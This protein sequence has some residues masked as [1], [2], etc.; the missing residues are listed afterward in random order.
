MQFRTYRVS[1]RARLRVIFHR[2]RVA[3]AS[4]PAQLEA[5]AGQR[6]AD[7]PCEMRPPLAPIQAR[8]AEHPLARVP[9]RRR[10]REEPLP[11]LGHLAAIGAQRD[12]PAVAQR[13]GQR[14][15]EPPGQV[16]VAGARGA[17][18]LAAAPGGRRA[19]ARVRPPPSRPPACARPAARPAGIA[20]A[21]LLLPVSSP[22][23]VSFARWPLVVCGD[24]WAA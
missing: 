21:A 15:A 4:D 20:V 9:A 24:T 13:I 7:A 18:R 3:L 19:P 14:D 1:R 8:P 2:A 12:V 5:P 6:G 17:Q 16:V 10:S 11:L 22:P 23:S